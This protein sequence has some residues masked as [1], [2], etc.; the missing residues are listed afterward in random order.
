MGTFTAGAI[1]VDFDILDLGPLAAAPI[2]GAT[3]TSLA[4][5]IGG[6]TTQIYGSGFTFDAAGPPTAGTF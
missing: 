5:I 1:G 6:V 2:S 4:L 3:P